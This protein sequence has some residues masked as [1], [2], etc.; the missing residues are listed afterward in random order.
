MYFLELSL[1]ELP[2]SAEP[3]STGDRFLVSWAE[4]C[5]LAVGPVDALLAESQSGVPTYMISE[6]PWMRRQSPG[7]SAGVA[8]LPGVRGS[9]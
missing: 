6:A 9:Q 1:G 7:R 4:F 2:Q 5:F 3:A 8:V